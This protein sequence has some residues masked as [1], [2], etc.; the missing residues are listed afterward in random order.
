[1]MS[2]TFWHG[3]GK[4]YLQTLSRAK[5]FRLFI[6]GHRVNTSS[7]KA[8]A[9]YNPLY[10]GITPNAQTHAKT[11]HAILRTP[12]QYQPRTKIKYSD[13]DYMRN[14]FAPDM[15]GG[16]LKLIPENAGKNHPSVKNSQSKID[17]LMTRNEYADEAV[18][19]RRMLP[20]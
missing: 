6:N 1:M 17:L 15:A 14:N 13:V 2:F 9:S 3:Q 19:L 20:K 7:A 5:S 10:S 16:S 18:R 8:G 11:Y 4:I 12:L